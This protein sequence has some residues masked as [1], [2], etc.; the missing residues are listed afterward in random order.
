MMY[1]ALPLKPDAYTKRRM[2]RAAFEAQGEEEGTIYRAVQA[3]NASK[4]RV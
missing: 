3:E 4:A 2:G 1:R